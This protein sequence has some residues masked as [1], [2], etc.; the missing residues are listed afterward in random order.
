MQLGR[1]MVGNNFQLFGFQDWNVLYKK[2]FT[3]LNLQ[4]LRNHLVKLRTLCN[5]VFPVDKINNNTNGNLLMIFELPPYFLF[6]NLVIFDNKHT[7]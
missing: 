2:R 7:W 3:W 1:E 5:Y 6:R 4:S